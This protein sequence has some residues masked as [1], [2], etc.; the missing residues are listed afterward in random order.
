MSCHFRFDYISYLMD[1]AI[2]ISILI[3]LLFYNTRYLII[4]IPP[5]KSIGNIIDKTLDLYQISINKL[6]K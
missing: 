1:Q 2:K 5:Q 4:R 3:S 6:Q